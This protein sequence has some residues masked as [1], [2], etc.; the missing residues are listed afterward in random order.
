MYQY[1]LWHGLLV[2]WRLEAGR[3]LD[4]RRNTY[5]NNN[6]LGD[7]MEHKKDCICYVNRGAYS[8]KD[9]DIVADGSVTIFAE[10]CVVFAYG[11]SEIH[12]TNCIVKSFDQS[13][14]Y[15]DKRSS[16]KAFD[17][18]KGCAGISRFHDKARRINEVN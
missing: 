18:S 10:R 14:V 15:A 5:S 3:L 13:T 8:A 7:R 9:C 1:L 12:A 4:C 16:L 11:K 17:E 6:L 2:E